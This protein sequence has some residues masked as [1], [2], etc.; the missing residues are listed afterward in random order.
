MPEPLPVFSPDDSARAAGFQRAGDLVETVP[1]VLADTLCEGV[2][3]RFNG[4][5][6]L[7]ALPVVDDGGNPVALLNRFRLLEKLSRRFGRDLYSRKRAVEC[8]DGAP[9]VLHEETPIE[10]RGISS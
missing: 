7:F 4:E 6:D 2:A 5:P 1:P 3:E 10:A 9:L 8:A